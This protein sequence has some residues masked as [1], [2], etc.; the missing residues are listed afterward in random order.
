[1]K[2]RKYL[3]LT[4]AGIMEALQ[5]RMA[6]FVMIVGN[7]LYLTIMF[8]LWKAIFASSGTDVVN[9]MTFETTLIYLVLATALNNFM[10]M[11]IVWEIGRNIQTGK[12]ALDLLRPFNYKSYLFWS[13][14]G[15]LFFDFV[16]TFLPTFVVIAFVTKGTIPLGINLLY[17]LIAV[18]FAMIINFNLDFIIGTVCLY[19]ESIWGINIMK[20]VVISLFSGAAIPLAFFPETFRQVVDWLPFRAICDTPLTILLDGNPDISKVA[21]KLSI[22]FAWVIITA[23]LSRV[24]WNVSIKQVTVNG[25]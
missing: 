5:F 2:I 6:T 21:I 10:E 7:L 23:V 22:S 3:A 13:Y 16:T 1:M 8:F 12:I 24:F 19:T 18:V 11:Y 20:Q 4:R 9:G 14:S 17:F 25:G 15:T